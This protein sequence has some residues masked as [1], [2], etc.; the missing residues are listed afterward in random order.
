MKAMILAAGRG[1]RMK[2]LTDSTPKP[3]LS[4]NGKSLIEYHIERLASLGIRDIVINC[5]WLAEQ[6]PERLGDGQK[7]GV[8][9]HYSVE[10]EGALETAGGIAKALP[11]LG[12]EP[13]LVI[14]GDIFLL[15]HLLILPT[16]AQGNL[17]HLFLVD[18][19]E[20]NVSGDFAIKNGMLSNL[21]EEVEQ[22]YTFSGIALYHP[23]F[24]DTISGQEK[25]ALGPM[26][27][28]GAERGVISAE[29]LKGEWTDVGT[30]ARLEELNKQLKGL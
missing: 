6:F 28:Q 20:H 25:I 13:F 10:S 9:I 17:A 29:L 27:R 8:N 23:T 1:E 12:N 11:M 15:P 4:V 18:N 7:F 24:F 22:S 14:N 19:P 2:P 16:L 3:L 26:L 5:A 21:N 30:P